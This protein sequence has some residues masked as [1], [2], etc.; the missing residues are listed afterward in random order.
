M[1]GTEEEE[2]KRTGCGAEEVTD[3]AEESPAA[4]AVLP[5]QPLLCS[6]VPPKWLPPEDTL[7]TVSSFRY[8]LRCHRRPSIGWTALSP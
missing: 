7:A 8:V 6:T 1:R 3:T 5:P 2:D 4:Q